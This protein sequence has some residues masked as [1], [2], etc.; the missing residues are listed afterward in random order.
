M[1]RLMKQV[2]GHRR[3]HAACCISYACTGW[4]GMLRSD[5]VSG[6]EGATA[7]NHSLLPRSNGALPGTRTS[8]N[9][10]QGASGADGNFFH[11]VPDGAP[12]GFC[13]FLLGF[14]GRGA[15]ERGRCRARFSSLALA[16]STCYYVRCSGFRSCTS[17]SVCCS[18]VITCFVFTCERTERK[19]R[20]P[21]KSRFIRVPYPGYPT[22]NPGGDHYGTVRQRWL[23]TPHS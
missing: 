11:G 10:S 6:R 9:V 14:P 18:A 8:Y 2:P 21:N 23:R 4:L 1:T 12:W 13:R 19:S 7:S 16:I 20:A 5:G 17:K 3:L 22:R 15:D